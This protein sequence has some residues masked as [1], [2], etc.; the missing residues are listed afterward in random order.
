ME[1]IKNVLKTF[2]WSRFVLITF[3]IKAIIFSANYA[4][5]MIIL[6]LIANEAFSFYVT[7]IKIKPIQ[8]SI[9]SELS[10]LKTRLSSIENRDRIERMAAQTSTNTSTTPRRMF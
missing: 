10:E 5:A 4:E 3:I 1:N 7:E 6:S 9:R 8:E 2:K